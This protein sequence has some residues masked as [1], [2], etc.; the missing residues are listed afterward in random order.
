M[1]TIETWRVDVSLS[2]RGDSTSAR[3]TLCLR[4]GRTLTGQ[5][6]ATRNPAD[7]E[8]PEIGAEVAG[9]RALADL[10][11]KLLEAASD[12]ISAVEHH[13]VHLPR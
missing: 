11:A 2:E 13:E 3:A 5:G 8:V 4:G 7:M 6:H 12:D 10:S 1:E 9:A